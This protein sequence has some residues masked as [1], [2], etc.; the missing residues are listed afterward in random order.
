M[1]V[2][3]GVRLAIELAFFGLAVTGLWLTGYRA[4]S[5]TLITAVALLYVITWD[6]QRWLIRQ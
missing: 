4:A 1:R 2:A 5:E 3:G 6:R